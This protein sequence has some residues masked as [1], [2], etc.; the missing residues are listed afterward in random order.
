MTFVARAVVAADIVVPTA[1]APTTIFSTQL[2]SADVD[3][4]LLGSWTAGVSV[5]TGFLVQPGVG[6]EAL[7]SFSA[8]STGF[9][10]TQTPD[11]TL[12]LDL[13][14]HYFLSVSILGDFSDNAIQMGYRGGPGDVLQSVI[15]GT[16]GV[17]IAPS[18]FLE[19][20]SQPTG[21]L[22]ASAS[23]QSGGSTNDLLLRWDAAPKKTKT[24]IGK[25]EL[26][27]QTLSLGSYTKGRYFFLPDAGI[28][29][30]SIKVF[31][32]YASG[33]YTSTVSSGETAARKYRLATYD[34]VILDST[35]GLVTLRN[36]LKT[37]VLV[38]YTKSGAS[39]GNTTGAT[40][41]KLDA[42]HLIRDPTQ[43]IAFTWS[44]AY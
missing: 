10:F 31:I 22:G 4:S 11:I 41:P 29:S 33:T 34:D 23:F 32:E 30:G 20:P 21:S 15:L 18:T 9:V 1:E 37:R 2:G 27:E 43:T 24:F 13:L 12:T 14:K 8:F 25:H 3:L 39:V 5:G 42:T 36:A 19:I 6:L 28:D 26:V 16:Q 17:T 38:Y 35:N 7:D 44:T 40:V